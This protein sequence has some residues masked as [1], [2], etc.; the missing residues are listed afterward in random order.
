MPISDYLK[1]L[2]AKIGT[3]LLLVPGVNAIVF[4]DA[5][6]ILLHRALDGRWYTPGG[7][8]DPG[9]QP[10]DAAAR[11]VLEETGVTVEP[12]RLV[13]IFTEE[14]V[15][16]PNGDRV[17]YVI[18][19]FACRVISGTPRVADDESLEVRFFPV[20]QLPVLRADQRHRIDQALAGQS[21]AFQRGGA[22][23]ES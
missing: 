18:M 9:E 7:A 17:Q 8:V 16:Y 2:R 21:C 3:D 10:A 4:N 1:H 23:H 13:G 19:T 6:E 20:D 11:E 12:E 14:P 22:W 5:G 15:A